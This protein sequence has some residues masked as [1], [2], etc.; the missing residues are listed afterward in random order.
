MEHLGRTLARI[1]FEKA[2]IIKSGVPVVCGVD[3]GPALTV[4]RRRAA[5]ENAP[6]VEVFSRD[7]SFKRRKSTRRSSFEYKIGGEAF[8][9]EPGLRGVHQGRNAAVAVVTAGVLGGGWRP[10]KKRAIEDGIR[11]V[12]WEGR[13]EEIGRSPRVFLDGAHNEAGAVAL[14]E[15]IQEACPRPPVLVFVMM[16]DKSLTRVSRILFPLAQKIILTK[17]P[18]PRA[19]GPEELRAKARPFAKKIIIEPDLRKA[20]ALARRS[21]G[22]AGTVFVTGSLFLVGEVKKNL[23]GR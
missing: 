11:S 1:A 14:S 4:I 22:S 6:F 5:E 21:A 19:A 12:V 20:L 18:Y 13:L 2:G 10:L 9:L 3:R 7:T 8:R 16:K 17:I 23:L 15:F